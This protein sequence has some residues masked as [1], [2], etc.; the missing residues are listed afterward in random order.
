MAMKTTPE[1]L[2]LPKEGFSKL[3]QILHAL[4]TSRT[5]FYD[6]IRSGKY[7]A[8]IKRGRSS[9]WPVGQIRALIAELGGE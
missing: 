6:G 1:N 3:P 5:Q 8:P 7:P 4:Q 2:D 9:V